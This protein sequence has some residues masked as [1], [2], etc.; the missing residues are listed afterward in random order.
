MRPKQATL[1]ANLFQENRLRL[2]RRSIFIIS[3]TSSR[4]GQSAFKSKNTVGGV[5][6]LPPVR[7]ET[8]RHID[9]EQREVLPH[10][11]A[12]VGVPASVFQPPVLFG[13][14]GS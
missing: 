12:L 2:F 14:P 13:I 3:S 9:H 7:L 5:G 8:V 10:G 1:F 4:A 11:D 6:S